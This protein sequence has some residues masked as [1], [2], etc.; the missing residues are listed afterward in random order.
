M[1]LKR[2]RTDG[3]PLLEMPD[4]SQTQQIQSQL[5]ASS[6]RVLDLQ[7][8]SLQVE[9][10]LFCTYFFWKDFKFHLMLSH[11]SLRLRRAPTPPTFRSFRFRIRPSSPRLT[12]KPRF[13][14]P[15]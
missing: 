7:L 10:E 15:G 8:D 5:S 13:A 1:S 14:C 4:L 9:L 2:K 12:A 3:S 6:S 11:E